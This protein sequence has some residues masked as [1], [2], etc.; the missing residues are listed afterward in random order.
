MLSL[1]SCL[2]LLACQAP[3][4]GRHLDRDRDWLGDFHGAAVVWLREGNTRQTGTTHIWDW[5]DPT[6]ENRFCIQLEDVD[7]PDLGD[8]WDN[9]TIVSTG[10]GTLIATLGNAGCVEIHP[11]AQGVA[12]QIRRSAPASETRWQRIRPERRGPRSVLIV[13]EEPKQQ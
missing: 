5:P 3:E 6:F 1:L 9:V 4:R 7:L 12:D 8:R 11:A 10:A 2:T 13:I